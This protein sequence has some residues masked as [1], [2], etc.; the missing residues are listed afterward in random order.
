M[1][2][3]THDAGRGVVGEVPLVT[4]GS[5]LYNSAI[6]VLVRLEHEAVFLHAVSMTLG[7]RFACLPPTSV[8]DI[9]W[10]SDNYLS[11]NAVTRS[12]RHYISQLTIRRLGPL[13]RRKR[14]LKD[15]S[16]IL[17]LFLRLFIVRQTIFGTRSW[18][19]LTA[20]RY[21]ESTLHSPRACYNR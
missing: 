8:C 17:A 16:L 20:A 11:V 2:S 15:T 3:R 19:S 5:I 9:T 18:D 7:W 14:R 12:W 6:L 21:R 1:L 4:V 10:C 13:R